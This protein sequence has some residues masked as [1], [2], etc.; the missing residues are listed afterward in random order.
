MKIDFTALKFNAHGF[1][2]AIVQDA[3]DG[4]VLCLAKMDGQALAKTAE[5]GALWLYDPG[6]KK[7]YDTAEDG[8]PLKV[9]EISTDKNGGTLLVKALPQKEGLG[10]FETPVWM[11]DGGNLP[12]PEPDG[13]HGVLAELYR[14]IC[15]KRKYGGEKSYTRYL[16]MSGQ[17]KILKKLG[18]ET[19]STV[20]ASKNDSKNEVLDEMSSLWYHCLVLLAYHNINPAELL[21]T[22]GDKRAK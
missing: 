6:N 13:I 15:Y 16:F 19:T 11:R 18:E 17:D 20:I 3:A 21:A 10:V 2:N 14:L 8:A 1:I 4:E 9:T 22:M 12:V 5:T 7:A